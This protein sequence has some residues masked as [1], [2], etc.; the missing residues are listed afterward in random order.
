[1]VGA[2]ADQS[3][4]RALI[5]YSGDLTGM[6]LRPFGLFLLIALIVFMISQMR[7]LKKT[8]QRMK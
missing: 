2:I 5:T 4:R 7:F 8:P 3:L 6:L 1:M